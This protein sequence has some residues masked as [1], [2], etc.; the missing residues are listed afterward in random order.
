LHL[1]A[2]DTSAYAVS[3]ASVLRTWGPVLYRGLVDDGLDGSSDDVAFSHVC[4]KVVATLA[5]FLL[6]GG[7][8]KCAAFS[9]TLC[10]TP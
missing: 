4:S 1:Q 8:L 3:I 2:G 10:A 7:I 6:N 9:R 5:P